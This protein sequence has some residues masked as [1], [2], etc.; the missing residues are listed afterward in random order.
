MSAMNEFKIKSQIQT[1]GAEEK[2]LAFDP[3]D[4]LERVDGDKEFLGELAELFY[5]SS[6][7]MITE[8]REAIAAGDSEL[9]ERHSH[10]LKGAVSNFGAFRAQNLSFEMEKIGKNGG[11]DGAS[12]I[13]DKLVAELAVLKEQLDEILL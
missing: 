2:V 12:D 7:E 3:A 6:E 10:S 4:A 8:L 9:L 1:P 13:L 11:V 5:E